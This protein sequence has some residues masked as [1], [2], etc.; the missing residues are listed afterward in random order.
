MSGYPHFIIGASLGAGIQATAISVVEQEVHKGDGWQ[1]ETAALRL[2]HLERMP[3]EVS[4]PDIVARIGTLLTAP[5]IEDGEKCGGADVVL[6]VTGSG[7]AILELFVR[8]EIKPIVVTI[9]GAGVLEEKLD[10]NDW[11]VPKI[12]LVG[13]LRVLYEAGR[14]RMAQA[15]D[16]VP[17]LL[18]ELRNFKM[19]PPRIDLSNPESWREGQFDDLVFAVAL[20]AW[21]ANRHVPTPKKLDDE[22]T[23]KMKELDKEWLR[24]VV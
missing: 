7:R 12:E 22:V 2:R 18:D 21:R 4:Y 14:M 11:R 1:P 20:A 3:L 10:R 8:D 16:L 19:R 13:A 6:D 24:Y 15:L 5:E 17:T 23:R 9:T